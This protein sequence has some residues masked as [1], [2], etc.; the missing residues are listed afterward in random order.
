M[1]N[2]PTSFQRITNWKGVRAGRS[3]EHY[4]L[5]YLPCTQ[6][7]VLVVREIYPLAQ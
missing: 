7:P 4:S 3:Q 1:V 6:R 5:C 2:L